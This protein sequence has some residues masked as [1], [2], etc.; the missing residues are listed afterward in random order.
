L[1]AVDSLAQGLQR[2]DAYSPS[3]AQQRVQGR[4]RDPITPIIVDQLAGIDNVLEEDQVPFDAELHHR[5]KRRRISDSQRDNASYNSRSTV[6]LQ[7]P[8]RITSSLSIL[9][10]PALF[11]S[12]DLATYSHKITSARATLCLQRNSDTQ[13]LTSASCETSDLLNLLSCFAESILPTIPVIDLGQVRRMI[14]RMD[15]YGVPWN[16]EACLVLL[17][18][19]L[20]SIY[21]PDAQDSRH[22]TRDTSQISSPASSRTRT[23]G[24]SERITSTT[25]RYWNMARKRLSW[26]MN[27]AGRLSTQCQLLAGYVLSDPAPG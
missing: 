2:S 27:T 15:E 26:A 21:Q 16:G 9:S 7:G 23:S 12:E 25:L 17:V 20:G 13:A 1:Q 24:T 19:A 11:R 6:P 10:W 22:R 5:S 8:T 14:S 18:A 3:R 4:D